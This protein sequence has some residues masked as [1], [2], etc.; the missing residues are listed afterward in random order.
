[1][2]LITFLRQSDSSNHIFCKPQTSEE[3][4]SHLR[5][6]LKSLRIFLKRQAGFKQQVGSNFDE[7]NRKFIEKE[8]M[9]KKIKKTPHYLLK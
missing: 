8:K 3:P 6:P 7:G 5:S 9:S 4:A 2:L 1:M